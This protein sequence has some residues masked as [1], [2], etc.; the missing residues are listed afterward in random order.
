MNKFGISGSIAVALAILGDK[1]VPATPPSAPE[2]KPQRQPWD[3]TMPGVKGRRAR[4]R[5][6]SLS[7]RANRC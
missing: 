2:G 3:V 7:R 5:M 6:Q 4:R 1:V